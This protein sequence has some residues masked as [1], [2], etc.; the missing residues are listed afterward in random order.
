[1]YI[2][3]CI[4]QAT[5]M[6][7][8]IMPLKNGKNEKI[9]I[10]VELYPNLRYKTFTLCLFFSQNIMSNQICLPPPNYSQGQ[11]VTCSPI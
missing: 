6:K 4:K 3:T 7:I 9:N 1:M 10:Q 5:L 11:V 8:T 2:L